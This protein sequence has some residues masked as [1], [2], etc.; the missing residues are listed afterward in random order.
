MGAGPNAGGLSRKHVVE[1][2]HASLRRLGLQ[3]VDLYQCH[4]FDQ[5]TPLE[6]TCRAMDDLIR[7]GEVLYWGVSEWTPDQMNDAVA[8]CERERLH[9][10]VSDQPRY[11]LLERTIEGDVLRAC[12]ELGLGAVVFSPLAQGVLTG[13]YRRVDEVPPDSRAADPTGAGFIGRL[14]TEENLARVERLRPIADQ[15]GCTLAQLALA[16]AARRSEVSSVIVGASN[17]RQLGENLAA[18]NVT[19]DDDVVERIEAAVA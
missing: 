8:I 11:S 3:Y 4:R 15:L 17:L 18:S 12:R 2:C 16:W 9:P 1:Q 19:L 6:E 14:L 10:P 5:S 7:G 13:K